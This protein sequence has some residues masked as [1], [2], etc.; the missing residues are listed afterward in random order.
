MISRLLLNQ[1][2]VVKAG[3]YFGFGI[4]GKYKAGGE[5]I[6][7]FKDTKDED[8]DILM[9][10]AKKFDAGLG[11][12]VAYEI[13]KFFIDLTGEFGLTKIYDGDGAPKN[14]N[15]SIGVGYKF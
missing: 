2:I 9:E 7:F 8:G 13:N 4:A 11:V 10:G 15:F 14:I 6:D 12:G 5:K 3:P 1:N